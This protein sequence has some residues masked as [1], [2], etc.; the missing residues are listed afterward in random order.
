[1]EV[2]FTK[3]WLM[4][5]SKLGLTREVYIYFHIKFQTLNL[6]IVRKDI[7]LLLRGTVRK[8][9][10]RTGRRTINHQTLLYEK[11]ISKVKTF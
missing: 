2:D 1:M 10:N 3:T 11:Y 8:T 6:K 5:R 7:D 4:S 9:K